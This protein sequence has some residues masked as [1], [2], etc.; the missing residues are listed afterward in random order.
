VSLS[1][2]LS[3]VMV[4][5]ACPMIGRESFERCQEESSELKSMLL[6]EQQ[7]T[8]N[9][10]NQIE[11]L[12]QRMSS[13]KQ[14][15]ITSLPLC[16]E[17]SRPELEEE[18]EEAETRTP[19]DPARLWA[20]SPGE[21]GN[22]ILKKMNEILKSLQGTINGILG[23]AVGRISAI[24]IDR[25]VVLLLS[26]SPSPSSGTVWKPSRRHSRL[27]ETVSIPRDSPRSYGSWNRQQVRRFCSKKLS[28]ATKTPPMRS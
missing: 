22:T 21:D 14:L 27:Q 6:E 16:F 3:V 11:V 2:T 5:C 19:Y 20:T 7:F 8:S 24:K 12:Q 23:R 13:W 25:F 1:T 28:V 4:L 18:E 15:L 10:L 9:Q 17:S 26:P